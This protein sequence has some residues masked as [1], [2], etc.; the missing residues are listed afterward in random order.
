MDVMRMREIETRIIYKGTERG[1]Q[2][3]A[4]TFH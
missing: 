1:K 3:D 2:G 4:M